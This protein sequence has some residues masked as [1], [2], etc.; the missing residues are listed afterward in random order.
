MSQYEMNLL[1]QKMYGEAYILMREAYMDKALAYIKK[2]GIGNT[3]ELL[4][5]WKIR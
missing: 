3:D 5:V 2:P 4:S 1:V